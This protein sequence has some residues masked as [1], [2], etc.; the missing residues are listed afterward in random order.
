MPPK[1]TTISLA[2]KKSSILE[3]FQ[4]EHSVYNIKELEKLIP[5]KCSGVASMLVKDL[6]QQMIDEDGI[7]SVEK[8]GNTNI[9]WCF[10]NQIITKMSREIDML[11]QRIEAAKL[12][13]SQT[14]MALDVSTKSSRKESFEV[15]GAVFSRA[16]KLEEL[17]SLDKAVKHS[18]SVYDQKSEHTWD[19]AKINAKTEA[20]SAQVA[21]LDTVTDNIELIVSFLCRRFL[22]DKRSLQ[23]ELGIP[24]EFLEFTNMPQTSK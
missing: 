19:Q 8:C 13:I 24:E 20:L 5:K 21:K 17:E 22:I 15:D 14:K 9:Y 23:S 3:F 18:R 12:E 16:E 4:C 6:I 7:I 10:R 11:N 1:R 2:Q